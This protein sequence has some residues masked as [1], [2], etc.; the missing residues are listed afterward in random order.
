MHIL[1]VKNDIGF[2][3]ETKGFYHLKELRTYFVNKY[4]S[5]EESQKLQLEYDNDLEE[6]IEQEIED[7]FR[8]EIYQVIIS[9]ENEE[10]DF[11]AGDILIDTDGKLYTLDKGKVNDFSLMNAFGKVVKELNLSLLKKAFSEGQLILICDGDNEEAYVC[12]FKV[13]RG[14]SIVYEKW[15][16]IK[17][18]RERESVV[19]WYFP[20]LFLLNR[21]LKKYTYK[22][23]LLFL[24]K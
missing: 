16:L 2:E 4:L 18:I 10:L 23:Q 17:Q 14:A 9:K 12:F 7:K 19:V 15:S 20:F 6:F 11:Y 5:K 3:V 1:I 24:V 22:N 21:K 13:I 8:F